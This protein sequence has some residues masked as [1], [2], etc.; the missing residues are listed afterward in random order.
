MPMLRVVICKDPTLVH[1]KLD[2]QAM[3]KHV[4]VS[5]FSFLSVCFIKKRY[6][7]QF[8]ALSALAEKPGI[9]II[10]YGNVD[11]KDPYTNVC[12]SEHFLD[13]DECSTNSHS[14]D[15]N[16]ACSN[17]QGSYTCACKAGYSGDGKTCTGKRLPLSV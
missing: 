6:C 11:I 5:Y 8:F 13:I 17:V 4:L 9:L 16:A 10:Y 3:G 15:V 1:A 12:F 14:C 2:I 7:M